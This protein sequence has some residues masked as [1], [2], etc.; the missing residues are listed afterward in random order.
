M[1]KILAFFRKETVLSVAAVLAICSAFFVT[2]DRQYI[3]YIDFPVLALLFCLMVVM[4]GFQKIG[5][6]ARLADG[7]LAEIKDTK[8]LTAVL[9]FLCFLTSM[10]ITNDVALITFVPFTLLML[11]MIH[12][13]KQAIR[14]V[15]LQTIAANLGSMLTPIGNPQNL[16]L[17]TLTNMSIGEFIITM[18]PYVVVSF[19]ILFC[20]IFFG[21]KESITKY[22]LENQKVVENNKVNIYVIL[23]I[24]CI[25]TVVKFLPYY[26]LIGIVIV[27]MFIVD[28][29]VLLHVDYSLLLTFVSFFIFIGNLG[30]MESV[31]NTLEQLV[32]G[33]ELLTSIVA[34]QVISN[35]P[36]AILLSEFTSDYKNLMIGVNLGGLGTLV[37]SL[38]SLISYKY[39]AHEYNNKKGG[40]IL[41]FTAYNLIFLGILIGFSYFYNSL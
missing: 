8:Q 33:K 7:L 28:R 11:P 34:S 15:V 2:P 36:A 25:L 24:L 1:K 9:V 23:F 13:E 30:R 12:Q 27:V 20:I 22:S 40:Y 38:A 14:I 39:F 26:Y 31:R 10:F 21:K 5:F 35:V 18:L 37:A 32:Q 19:I 29:K 17:Y 41:V 6:F 4:G 3:D 16:Y